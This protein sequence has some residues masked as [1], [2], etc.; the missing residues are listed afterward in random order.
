MYSL[1]SQ[2]DP[3]MAQK[4]HSKDFRKIEKSLKVFFSTG[5]RQSEIIINQ[6]KNL[7]P[8]YSSLILCLTV[9]KSVLDDRIDKRVDKMM[10]RG[11]LEEVQDAWKKLKEENVNTNDHTQGI[12]QAIGLKEFAPLLQRLDSQNGNNTTGSLQDTE[13][14]SGET[15][16]KLEKDSEGVKEC[17]GNIKLHTRQYSRVQMKWIRKLVDGDGSN[18]HIPITYLDATDLSKWDKMVYEPALSAVLSFLSENSNNLN[19]NN[20][21]TNKVHNN[22]SLLEWKK[23]ICDVCHGKSLNG[24][25]EWNQHCKSDAHITFFFLLFFIDLH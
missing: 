21:N 2:V 24:L 8:A 13:K 1:L 4:I 3:I 23:Y 6:K 22:N 5:Q 17:A 20:N 9:D 19:N 18:I 14:E 15:L 25:N 7:K 12:L 11:L 10:Q 16:L